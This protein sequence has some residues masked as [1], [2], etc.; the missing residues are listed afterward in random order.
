M[1]TRKWAPKL[2]KSWPCLKCGQP[3]AEMPA[4]LAHLAEAHP[5]LAEGPL[6]KG[7]DN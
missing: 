6:M 5:E 3:Q 4:Y 2:P 1:K 7:D